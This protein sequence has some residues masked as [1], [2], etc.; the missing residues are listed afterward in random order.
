MK[1]EGKFIFYGWI[2]SY[3][4]KSYE[5]GIKYAWKLSTKFTRNISIRY[6]L[7]NFSYNVPL[8][9]FWDKK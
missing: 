2:P 6:F 4:Q 8:F 3:G 1:A 5:E 7:N 9:L